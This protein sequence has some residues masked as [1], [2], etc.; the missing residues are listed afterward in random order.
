M[1]VG[2]FYYIASFLEVCLEDSPLLL[3]NS[4]VTISCCKWQS[5][6]VAVWV[7]ERTLLTIKLLYHAGPSPCLHH[8]SFLRRPIAWLWQRT[9]LVVY[10]P[11]FI[12]EPTTICAFSLWVACSLIY[13]LLLPFF[14]M[15]LLWLYSS[16]PLLLCFF[17]IFFCVLLGSVP[18]TFVA[19]LMS[20]SLIHVGY[21]VYIFLIL[22]VS[23]F[24]NDK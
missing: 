16:C 10:T 11:P 3:G 9:V 17:L 13:P 21:S 1:G 23:V 7:E 15:C 22:I 19:A 14:L 12:S 6:S 4:F 8:P 18:S 24:C 2:G 5:S 20:S